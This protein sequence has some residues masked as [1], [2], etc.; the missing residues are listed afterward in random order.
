MLRAPYNASHNHSHSHGNS[1]SNSNSGNKN[2]NL[3][4]HNGKVPRVFRFVLVPFSISKCQQKPKKEKIINYELE[5]KQ[6]A[7][8]ELG[9]N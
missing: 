7:Q 6:K 8:I 1:N 4:N 9:V 2:K 5:I 3:G